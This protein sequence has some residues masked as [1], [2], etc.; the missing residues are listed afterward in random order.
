MNFPP[1]DSA[2]KKRERER[3][4]EELGR[5]SEKKRKTLPGHKKFQETLHLSRI[6]L[7]NV[8]MHSCSLLLSCSLLCKALAE[9]S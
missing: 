7:A 1:F 3:E 2:H 5:R 9:I 4:R 8:T 6:M